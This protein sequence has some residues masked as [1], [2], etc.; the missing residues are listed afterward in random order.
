MFPIFFPFVDGGLFCSQL[1]RF[2]CDKSIDE[3]MV[4][5][6]VDKI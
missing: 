5:V 3:A 1:D 4:T 2:T 6:N